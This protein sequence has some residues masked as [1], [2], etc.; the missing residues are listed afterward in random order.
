MNKKAITFGVT[1]VIM[2]ILIVGIAIYS[3]VIT[4]KDNLKYTISAEALLEYEKEIENFQIYSEES[5][6]LAASQALQ[7]LASKSLIEDKN[8]LVYNYK[9]IWDENCLPSNLK[10]LF[11]EKIS[12][13]FRKHIKDYSE[14]YDLIIEKQEP[15]IYVNDIKLKNQLKGEVNYSFSHTLY[16]KQDISKYLEILKELDEIY[17]K[18][19]NAQTTCANSNIAVCMKQKIPL[20]HWTLDVIE[21]ASYLSINLK[22]K[23]KFFFVS[24]GSLVW[25]NIKIQALI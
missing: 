25:D 15:F 12:V 19:K 17:I 11:F 7:D 24:G 13:N 23:E 5:L 20:N 3:F 21:D 1:F 2:T 22:T 6:N 16:I 18:L 4:Q 14:E 10:D 9:L 8:C